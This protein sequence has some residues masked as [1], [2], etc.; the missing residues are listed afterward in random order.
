MWTQRYNSC[1]W[2]TPAS[3]STKWHERWSDLSN[4]FCNYAYSS[5]RDDVTVAVNKLSADTWQIT[6][7]APYND[8]RMLC[9][10]HSVATIRLYKSAGKQMIK[11]VNWDRLHPAYNDQSEDY[12]LRVQWRT[13]VSLANVH[14]Y[15]LDKWLQ[16]LTSCA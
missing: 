1:N 2:V 12:I 4:I 15:E 10:F 3:V 7:S 13:G 16:W 6:A 8:T 9:G 5:L 11:V 14:H